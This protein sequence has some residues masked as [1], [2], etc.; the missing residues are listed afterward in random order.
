MGA[1]TAFHLAAGGVPDV[2]VLERE[3]LASGSTSRSAG[4]AR[5]QFAD[6][7]NV[8]LSLRSLDEFEQ[9][10]ALI[11]E[12]VEFVPEIAF[13]QHGYLFLLD[14]PGDVEL[15]REALLV[16]H[17]CGVPSRELTPAEA[18]E[19]VPQLELDGVLAA[20]FCP[21]DG[22][23]SPEA[24]VQGYAAAAVAC[25][26]RV[27]QGCPALAIDC[28]G[29]RITGVRTAQ[30][31]VATD[32]VVCA[33]GAWSREVGAMAGI[34][35]PVHGEPRHMWFSPQHGGL[36]DDLP[37]T[38]DF[39]TSFY[40]HREGPGIVFGG[41]ESALEEV[42]EHAL[43]RLPLIL[44]LPIQSSW[45]GFY[46]VSPDHNA[47]VGESPGTGRFL[48]ATGFSGHGFQQSPAIGEHLAQ[49][50]RGERPSFDLSALAVERFA[51]GEQRAERFVV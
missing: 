38:I 11:G 19:L 9:W 35:I 24:V 48:Y 15:F 37:L 17:A 31:T 8:G 45:W 5:L 10:H 32:T 12:H 26:A 7:L 21:R 39:T 36:R 20:T 46:E 23:M 43:E 34:E 22:H 13:H 14:A 47:I 50:V 44:E 42:A 18:A 33:A 4:G 49:L 29:G 25:G 28:A 40:F 6:E 3:T 41:R 51:R 27:A 16:Q 2:L 1:S 30:G